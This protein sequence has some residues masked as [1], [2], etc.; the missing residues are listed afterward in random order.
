MHFLLT[1]AIQTLKGKKC[2]RVYRGVKVEIRPK[3][4][5]AFRFGRFASTS[6]NITAAK[7]FGNGTFFRIKTC[8]GANISTYSVYQHE[9]E[10]LIPPYE[11]FTVTEVKGKDVTLESKKVT[12][13]KRCAPLPDPRKTLAFM[14]GYAQRRSTGLTWRRARP[15]DRAKSK[16]PAK[17]KVNAFPHFN[18]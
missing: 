16:V 10:V 4:S 11:E 3:V 17:G 8:H 7:D 6:T 15:I 5:D 12:V 18:N 14:K 2:T 13:Y 1:K 9:S